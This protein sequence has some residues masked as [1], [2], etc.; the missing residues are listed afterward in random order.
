MQTASFKIWTRIAVSISY[1]GN[2]CIIYN[3][4]WGARIVINPIKLRLEVD[5]MSHPAHAKGVCIYVYIYIYICT[6]GRFTCMY[7]RMY[8][9]MYL[10]TRTVTIGLMSRVFANGAG[11]RVQSQVESYQRPRK[12][13]SMPPC[14]ALSIIR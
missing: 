5:V 6:R 4:K 14:L 2:H 13:F 3:R 11:D 1:D 9:C 12:W 10:L 7:V 8:V